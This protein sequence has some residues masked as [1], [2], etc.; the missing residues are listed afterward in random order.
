MTRSLLGFSFV[1]LGS[2]LTLVTVLGSTTACAPTLAQPFAG[3]KNQPITV[4]RLQNFEPPE[5]AAAGQSPIPGVAIPPQI[6]SWLHGAAA[7]LPPGLIPPG[8]LPGSAPVPG[9]A[10]AP[11]FYGFRIIASVQ[12]T[13]PKRQEEILELFGKES[14]FQAP[15]QS[16]FY[17]EWGFSIGQQGGTPPA[18]VLVSQSCEQ[19]KINNYGWPHGGGTKTGLTP[20]SVEKVSTI[21]RH[22]FGG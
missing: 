16:C 22:A 18:D 2:A 14:N 19:V 9:T 1:G 17:A 4:H 10:N 21:I 12:I 7:A 20:D 11:R 15:R 6:Q 3:M 13:D 8:L 5:Q